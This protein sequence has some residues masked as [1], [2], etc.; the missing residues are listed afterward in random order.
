MCEL[1]I[2]LK[3]ATAGPRHIEVQKYPPQKIEYEKIAVLSD[4]RKIVV[5]SLLFYY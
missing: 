1:I 4:I 3:L 2:N 5:C